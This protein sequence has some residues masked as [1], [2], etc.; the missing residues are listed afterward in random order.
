MKVT[1]KTVTG[2]N[3]SLELQGTEKVGWPAHIGLQ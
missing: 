1:F 3:F 2:A